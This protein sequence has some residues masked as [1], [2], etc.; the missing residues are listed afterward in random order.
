MKRLIAIAACSLLLCACVSDSFVVSCRTTKTI[1]TDQMHRS[2]PIAVK[3]YQLTSPTLFTKASVAAVWWHANQYL[4]QSLLSTKTVALLPGEKRTVRLAKNS[5]TTALGFVA[6]FRVSDLS[7]KKC[8]SLQ[9]GLPD[10]FM[11]LLHEN[12]LEVLS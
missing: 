7:E 4:K 6:L 10:H 3:I 11:L 2:L 12:H 9:R 5:K 1:N 8:F